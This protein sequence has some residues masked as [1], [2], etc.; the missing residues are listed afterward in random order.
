MALIVCFA[1]GL[2]GGLI[3]G[4]LASQF[5][6]PKPYFHDK[7]HFD[8]CE[9]GEV[10]QECHE[11]ESKEESSSKTSKSDSDKSDKSSSEK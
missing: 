8:D 5:E 1:C 3:A 2:I 11:C 6:A 9:Y 10:D 4:Y 7:S